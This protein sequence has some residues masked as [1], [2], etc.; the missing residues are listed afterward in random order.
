M[1]YESELHEAL[2]DAALFY[3]EEVSRSTPTLRNYIK[4]ASIFFEF[5]QIA[6]VT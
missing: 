4:E 2:Q 6:P 5:R 1:E 3:L